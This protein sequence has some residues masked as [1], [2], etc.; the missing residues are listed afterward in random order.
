MFYWPFNL[1]ENVL[2]AGSATEERSDN[3]MFLHI[4]KESL[5]F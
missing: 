4:A 3:D 5:K 1:K 2:H